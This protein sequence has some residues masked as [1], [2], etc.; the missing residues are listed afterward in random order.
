MEAVP[1]LRSRLL[2]VITRPAVRADVKG[3][4]RLLAR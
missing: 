4:G 1:R 3:M 2:R